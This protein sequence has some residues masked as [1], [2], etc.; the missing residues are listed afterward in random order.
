VFSQVVFSVF[1]NTQS[2]I[3][4]ITW[5]TWDIL[6]TVQWFCLCYMAVWCILSVS[7]WRCSDCSRNICLDHVGSKSYMM[8]IFYL[9]ESVGLLHKFR[10]FVRCLWS[11]YMAQQ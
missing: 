5:R 9:C 8:N 4:I 10:H 6:Y 2:D 11:V 1:N 7:L 3:F